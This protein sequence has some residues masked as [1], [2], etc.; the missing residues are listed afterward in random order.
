MEENIV[1][2]QQ[3]CAAVRQQVRS[4]AVFTY[5]I[6]YTATDTTDGITLSQTAGVTFSAAMSLVRLRPG[7][8]TM[9]Q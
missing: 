5:G 8:E 4:D 3:Y 6:T 7:I 1:V 9:H 2:K